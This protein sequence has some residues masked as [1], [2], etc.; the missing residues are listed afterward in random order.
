LEVEN[1]ENIYP[2]PMSEIFGSGWRRIKVECYYSV[3]GVPRRY[4]EEH[5]VSFNLSR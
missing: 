4:M 2:A 5:M 3:Y 1:I